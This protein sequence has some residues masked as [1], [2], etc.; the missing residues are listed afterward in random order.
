MLIAE[1]ADLWKRNRVLNLSIPTGQIVT[2]SNYITLWFWTSQTRI[3]FWNLKWEKNHK[4]CQIL[5]FFL[6]LSRFFYCRLIISEFF[7]LFSFYVPPDIRFVRNIFVF[8]LFWLI[9]SKFNI[10]LWSLKWKILRFIT[11]ISGR[12][13][14]LVFWHH[15]ITYEGR[16]RYHNIILEVFISLLKIN[17]DSHS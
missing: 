1:F 15:Y 5:T 9:R 2:L 11:P 4:S 14:V 16:G 12:I 8:I 6:S 7:L 3:N 13:N 10:Y 17:W